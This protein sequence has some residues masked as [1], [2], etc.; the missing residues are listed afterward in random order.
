LT[1]PSSS[2][3]TRPDRYVDTSPQPVSFV[4]AIARP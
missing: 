2:V 4:T 3:N 1:S